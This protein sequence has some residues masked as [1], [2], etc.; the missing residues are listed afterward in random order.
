VNEGGQGAARQQAATRF[1]RWLEKQVVFDARGDRLHQLE[2]K[3]SD[4]LW[5]GRLAPESAAWKAGMGERGQ[6]LD[7]CSCGFRFRPAAAPP[8]LWKAR[9]RFCVWARV[10]EKENRHW[11]KGDKFSIDIPIEVPTN[12]PGTHEFGAEAFAALFDGD[13]LDG[14]AAHVDVQVDREVEGSSVALVVVNDSTEKRGVDTNFYEVSLEL[15][16]GD[17]H[18]FILDSL[19]DSFRY[20]RRVIAYGVN[21]GVEHSDGVLRTS[22]VAAAERKRPQYWDELLGEEP[23]L[24]F[25]RLAEDPLPPLRELVEALR[26][27]GEREW[28]E[29]TLDQRATAEDW[30]DE[31]RGQA[32]EEAA[33]FATELKRSERGLQV[34][35][36]IGQAEQAFKLMNEAFV[37]SGVDRYDRWRPF[38]LG[39]LLASLPS[40]VDAGHDERELVDTL[41]F[42]TGGGKTETYLGVI[43][44]SC[45]YDRLRGKLHG[46]TAWSRFP[47]RMLSLQQTQRFADALAGA[48]LARRRA[49]IEG[50]PFALGF[51]VGRAGTP[52]RV[53]EEPAQGEADADDPEMPDH[54]R[55]LLRCPFCRSG[56]LVMHFDRR[57]WQLQ[58]RC[59]NEQCPWPE[60]GLP[61]YVVDEEIYRLLPTAIVGTL[62]KAASVSMQAAMR[63]LYASPIGLCSGPGHGF[64][65]APRKKTRG[66][67]VPG[68]THSPLPLPQ[69]V[70]LFAPTVRV[71]DELHLLRGGLGAIDAHYE[72]LLDHLYRVTKSPAAKVIASSATLAGYETQVETLYGRH[73]TAFPQPGPKEG[74]SFWTKDQDLLARR[75]VGLAPRGVTQEYA[76]DRIAESLQRAVRRLRDDASAVC[77]EA[78]IDSEYVEFLI[79]YYGSNVVYGNT[80]RDVEAAARSFETQPGVV[81]LNVAKLTGSTLLEDVRE[82][83]ERLDKPEADFDDRIHVVCASSMMSHGVDIDRFNVITMLGMPLATAEFIQTTARIGR[84][85]PGLVFVLH[86]MGVERDASVFR[87][88]DVFVRHGERFIEPIAITRKSRRVLNHTFSGLFMARVLGVHEPR[89]V[90]GGEK[91]IT[92]AEELRKY[93]QARPVSEQEEFESLCDALRLDPA[94][95]DD[96]LVQELKR[97][98]RDTFRELLDPASDARWPS[99]VTPRPP[100]LSLREVESQVPIYVSQNG[101]RRRR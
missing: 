40:L 51:L 70:D 87:S 32:S 68:C 33:R 93:V 2:T 77:S 74:T 48:E 35:A 88:F 44:F 83:L 21:G 89:R 61:F 55:V 59:P 19:P 27:W 72:T 98:V 80:V 97:L 54:N 23:D 49:G 26:V 39:F 57:H 90:R 31:M 95:D 50:D 25:D 71:Q 34:L 13:G 94:A 92:T 6:R 38:Q 22:D 63:G 53:R 66:C 101:R 81:P 5:L 96:P 9:V 100:M 79:S 42:A 4:R 29:A 47:L 45:L 78:D 56:D 10:G 7:P 16:V 86:R 99:E 46:V 11:R 24:R 20:D 30:S 76:N 91:Q 43:V 37:H 28:S 67:L 82:A 65:Y 58:H 41:W 12:E 69:E 85:F 84:A 15:E 60:T 18:P 1:V 64:T 8:W 3:P 36:T 52:N 75:F 73:G 14:Y 62:D 17:L